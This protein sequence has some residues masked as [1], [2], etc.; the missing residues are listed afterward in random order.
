MC[1]KY[2]HRRDRET[3]HGVVRAVRSDKDLGGVETVLEVASIA[4]NAFG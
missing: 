2:W 3:L 4:C 1:G